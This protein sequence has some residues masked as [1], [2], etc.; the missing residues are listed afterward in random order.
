MDSVER[1]KRICKERK[2]PISRL[3]KD[4]GFSNG[5]IGQL[6]KGTFPM[7]RAL[8]IAEYL[9][10]SLEYL[11]TGETK[12]APSEESAEKESTSP[13]EDEML[14]KFKAL[15]MQLSPELRPV[16]NTYLQ[17]LLMIQELQVDMNPSEI[18]KD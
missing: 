11:L 3:E 17:K 16:A 1:V 18:G 9:D 15:Y 12:N 8:A 4:L 13:I 7:D 14:S 2:I 10:L 6:R 5:Y